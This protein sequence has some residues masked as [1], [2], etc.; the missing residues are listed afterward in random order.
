[1]RHILSAI[2]FL[3]LAAGLYGQNKEEEK[4]KSV[5]FA[6]RD[7]WNR[8]DLEG[9]MEGY[10]KNDSLKFIGKSGI[11]RGWDKTLLNY[12]KGYPDKS[13]MGKLEF[14]I[15]ELTIL[16]N[17]AAFMIGKWDL[18]RE[19]DSPGGYFTL[20]WRKINGEWKVTADHSS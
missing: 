9:Y 12:K 6:Q 1:M 17:D 8:G 3:T 4:I 15:I 7:A 19:K 11:T 16:T 10:W 5:L 20:L 13:A 14:K 18:Q 2:L